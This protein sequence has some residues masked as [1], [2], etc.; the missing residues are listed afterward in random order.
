MLINN[1]AVQNWQRKRKI[2]F[3]A[4]F[5][6]HTRAVI[7]I[8]IDT[9]TTTA[10]FHMTSSASISEPGMDKNTSAPDLSCSWSFQT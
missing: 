1:A 9:T 10:Y 8:I 3:Y 4:F 6:R 7:V 5:E 2:P